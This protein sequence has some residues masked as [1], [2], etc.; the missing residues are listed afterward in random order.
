MGIYSDIRGGGAVIEGLLGIRFG[1]LIFGRAHFRGG[2]IIIGIL[3][4]FLI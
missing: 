3:K 2:G 4:V 1:G